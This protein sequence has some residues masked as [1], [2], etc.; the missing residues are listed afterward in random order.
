MITADR[1]CGGVLHK[2]RC[3]NPATASSATSAST[4]AAALS[5]YAQY[6]AAEC[7]SIVLDGLPAD[8][9]VGSR[10]LRL[11]NLFVPL[12]LDVHTDG[13]DTKAER[14]PVGTAL[15]KNPRIALLAA[16]GG[17]KSTLLKRLA[18]AYVDPTRREQIA[19]D[20]PSRD[21]LPLFFR[22][23]E[24]R[25]LAREP[26]ADLLDALSQR[27]PIRQYAQVFRACVDQALFA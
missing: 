11:E 19:D 8:G 7:G 14:Q 13:K 24:L 26:F 16:P 25:S 17:G 2:L 21:W 23:R 20:L 12:H 18:V 5:A 22:C 10:R 4:A 9:D 15:S 1:S 27:E 3:L 6:L